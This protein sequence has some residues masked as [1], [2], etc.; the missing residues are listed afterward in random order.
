MITDIQII[1]YILMFVVIVI[2][3]NHFKNTIN[4]SSHC[5]NN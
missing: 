4:S 5:D 2:K 3:K 1:I